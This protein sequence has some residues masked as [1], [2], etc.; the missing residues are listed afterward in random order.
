MNISSE[1]GHILGFMMRVRVT[2]SPCIQLEVGASAYLHADSRPAL[3]EQ[4]LEHDLPP[5][6]EC[7]CCLFSLSFKVCNLFASTSFLAERAEATRT[8]TGD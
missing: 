7:R 8:D 1:H 6:S 5:P 2:L 3:T 4:R